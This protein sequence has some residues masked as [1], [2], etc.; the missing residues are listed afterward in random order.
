MTKR[1]LLTRVMSVP[2]VKTNEDAEHVVTAIFTALRDRITPEEADDVWSQLP[3]AWKELWDSGSWWEK[4][5][6]RMRGMNKL[7]RDEFVARVRM[8]I[9]NDVPAEQA[10][11]AVFHAL[12]EQISPGE[13]A[14][15]SSQ[16]PE[17]LRT[18]WKAA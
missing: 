3:T 1:E 11:R 10:V 4:M 15:V 13:A 2:G 16:L 9:P 12:K 17:D 18:L 8:H 14:D 5:G 7:N 6:S